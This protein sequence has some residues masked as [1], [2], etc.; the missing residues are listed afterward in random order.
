MSGRVHRMPGVTFLCCVALSVLSAVLLGAVVSGDQTG[1][2]TQQSAP[3]PPAM[4][5]SY[6]GP[7]AVSLDR[8]GELVFRPGKTE[9]TDLLGFDLGFSFEEDDERELFVE[10]PLY[11]YNVDGWLKVSYDLNERVLR[12]W[13]SDEAT[14]KVVEGRYPRV[15]PTGLDQEIESLEYLREFFEYLHSPPP[16]ADDVDREECPG[17][18][19]ECVGKC[20]ACC[21][22][23]YHPSCVCG[24]P[25]SCKCLKEKPGVFQVYEEGER[26]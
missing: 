11:A 18:W 21:G 1:D 14:G 9:R 23:G 4:H 15:P 5:L 16:A 20:K 7:G 6:E 2:V 13:A 26:D 10:L 24:S 19:C 3:A 17:G 12:L 22:A 25:P 8:Y